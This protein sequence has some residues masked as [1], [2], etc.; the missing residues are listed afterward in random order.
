MV[1]RLGKWKI[2]GKSGPCGPRAME[3]VLSQPATSRQELG[4]IWCSGHLGL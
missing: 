2:P 4:R 3:W 1:P